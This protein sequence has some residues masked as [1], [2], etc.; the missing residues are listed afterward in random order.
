[1]PRPLRRNQG[2]D[3][4]IIGGGIAGL[5]AAWHAVG[6]GLATAL[7]ETMPLYGGQVATV[8]AVE[9][10]PMARATSGTQLATALVDAIRDGAALLP[11]QADAVIPTGSGF[12]VAQNG[13]MIRA[14]RV[15]VATGQTARRLDVAGEAALAG[16]GVSHCATCDG[17]LFRGEDVVVAGGGDAALQE[18]LTLAALC[19]RVSIVS[20]GKLRARRAYVDRA[21]KTANIRFI[22]DSVIDAILGEDRVTGV[23]LRECRSG[24]MREIACGGVFPFI[25]GVPNTKPLPHDIHRD[26]QGH[27]MTDGRFETALPGLYAIG[28]VRAGYCGELA[29]AA[30]EA[31]AVIRS[32]AS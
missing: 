21:V 31:A 14:R 23:R 28:A 18:A 4:L 2:Y 22:W 30:G 24:V 12:E 32:I 17:P 19:R 25:G 27:L 7:L 9:G 16:R 6:R 26:Q 1:M 20:R 5:M 15:I 11:D 10:L 3:V 13:T 8:A 29:S